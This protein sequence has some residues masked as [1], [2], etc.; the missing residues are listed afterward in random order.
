MQVKSKPPGKVLV[1]KPHFPSRP[2]KRGWG[3]RPGLTGAQDTPDMW[4]TK[5]YEGEDTKRLIANKK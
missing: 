4:P 5:H 2:V 1:H 3:T